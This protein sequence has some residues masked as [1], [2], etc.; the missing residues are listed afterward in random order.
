MDEA[1]AADAAAKS[2]VT[3]R[4][5]LRQRE[6]IRRNLRC[7]AGAACDLRSRPSSCTTARPRRAG[8]SSRARTPIA[9]S[10]RRRSTSS[11][12]SSRLGLEEVRVEGEDDASGPVVADRVYGLSERRCARLPARSTRSRGSSVDARVRELRREHVAEAKEGRASSLAARGCGAWCR[13]RP[14]R[15]RPWPSGA[16]SNSSHVAFAVPFRG[17]FERSG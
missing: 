16:A 1:K 17:P 11:R 3:S 15:M 2:P 12:E 13:R 7:S 14:R 8:S 4:Q 5:L 9:V 6:D 10:D